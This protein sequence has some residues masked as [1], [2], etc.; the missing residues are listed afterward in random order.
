MPDQV[1]CLSEQQRGLQDE[2]REQSITKRIG[3]WHARTD[4]Y[5][6]QE[7][8]SVLRM[9]VHIVECICWALHYFT[10]DHEYLVEYTEA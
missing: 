2:D 8:F 5:P 9:S 6:C 10:H 3:T 1:G 7:A 4:E